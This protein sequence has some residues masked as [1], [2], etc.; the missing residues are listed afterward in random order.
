M[1]TIHYSWSAC[2]RLVQELYSR[3]IWELDYDVDKNSNNLFN[4]RICSRGVNFIWHRIAATRTRILSSNSASKSN[5]EL[6]SRYR[7]NRSA[8]RR[9]HI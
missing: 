5:I 1:I 6:K 9:T 3:D 8:T 2:E 7:T 4:Q